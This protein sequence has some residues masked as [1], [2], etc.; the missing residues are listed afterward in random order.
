MKNLDESLEIINEIIEDRTVPRNI[1][2]TIKEIKE[3]LNS[4]EEEGI[5]K[6]KAMQLLDSITSDP[7]MPVYTRTQIW[8]LVSSIEGD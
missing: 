1:R 4:K 2:D 7:N 5:K 6:D 8:N 3:C